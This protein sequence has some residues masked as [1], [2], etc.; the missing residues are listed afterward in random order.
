MNV[1]GIH[2]IILIHWVY[3]DKYIKAPIGRNVFIFRQFQSFSIH[4]FSFSTQP[5]FC[6][7]FPVA[8]DP[9]LSIYAISLAAKPSVFFN[10]SMFISF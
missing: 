7:Y 10:Y 3:I 8:A 6:I 4:Y 1:I 2:Y 5:I 9:I